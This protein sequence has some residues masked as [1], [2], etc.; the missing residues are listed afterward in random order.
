MILSIQACKAST[1]LAI[2]PNLCLTTGCS[3]SFCPN[4][5]RFR[6]QTMASIRQVRALLTAWKAM[7]SRSWLKFDMVYLKP[8]PSC[9]TRYSTGTLTSS[10]VTY[11]VAPIPP[12]PI[13]ILRVLRP[14]S[15]GI[16]SI[17]MPAGPGPP[18]RTVVWTESALL[19]SK[20]MIGTRPWSS[21]KTF[22]WLSSEVGQHSY[23]TE[24]G[25][26]YL[27]FAI[28]YVILAISG[29]FSCGL[30]IL[31]I[32]TGWWL[33]DGKTHS[34]LP[35]E[36][37]RQDPIQVRIAAEIQVLCVYLLGL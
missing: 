27:L 10:N 33:S 32:W 2:C 36:N 20:H 28:D 22:R 4:V 8:S 21:R 29:L 9:P 6:H 3:I 23:H 34:L 19:K 1:C 11:V 16:S 15:R 26:T 13:S 30:Y 18:V 14:G 24:G 35:R 17:D 37:F 12:A 7:N 5:S 25:I 31:H